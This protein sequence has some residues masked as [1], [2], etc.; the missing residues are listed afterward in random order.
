MSQIY[1]F[2]LGEGHLPMR[3]M[4]CAEDLG[5]TVV[6]HTLSSDGSKLHWLTMEMRSEG[7]IDTL[8]RA[9][10][11]QYA[12]A[13]WLSCTD[14]GQA[15]DKSTETALL[16]AHVTCAVHGRL[17]IC[18]NCRAAEIGRRGGQQVTKRKLRQLEKARS[19]I[20][21]QGKKRIAKGG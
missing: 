4:R 7:V 13:E 18:P 21:P 9:Q 8:R 12:M 2:A 15:I 20:R 11:V 5:A 6:N 19:R 10:K 17:L 14:A 16:G 1:A 3:A